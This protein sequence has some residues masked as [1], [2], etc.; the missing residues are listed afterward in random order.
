MAQ[1]NK[2]DL[3]KLQTVTDK[4]NEVLKQL[5]VS[6][7]YK[8]EQSAR[9]H[10]AIEV[11]VELG[12]VEKHVTFG[13]P[14]YLVPSTA[15]SMAFIVWFVAAERHFKDFSSNDAARDWAWRSL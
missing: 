9:A 11:G 13:T 1:W 14:W 12:M 10:L 4:Q 5:L 2:Q 3:M 15:F 7:A 6:K 8:H